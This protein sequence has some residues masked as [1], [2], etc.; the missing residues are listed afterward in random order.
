MSTVQEH[1]G[2]A[3]GIIAELPLSDIKS[4]QAKSSE[5]TRE[6]SRSCHL[7]VKLLSNCC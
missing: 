4:N 1:L 5:L 6:L 7:T 3:R 2:R